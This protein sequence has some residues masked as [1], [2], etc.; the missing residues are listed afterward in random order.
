M[1]FFW[2]GL[3]MNSSKP[4]KARHIWLAYIIV[5]AV[6]YVFLMLIRPTS[7]VSIRVLITLLGSTLIVFILEFFSNTTDSMEQTSIHILNL[8][9]YLL[10]LFSIFYLLSKDILGSFGETV[11][12]KLDKMQNCY[13]EK[14]YE[15]QKGKKV[16][17]DERWQCK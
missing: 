11:K 8:I 4:L 12:N 17:I 3:K 5:I 16:L 6:L 13:I 7:K 10:L 1:I 9:M 15:L 14:I 2:I